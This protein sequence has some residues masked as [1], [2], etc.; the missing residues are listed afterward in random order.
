MNFNDSI[1]EWVKIDNVQ[2]EYLDKLKE[3]REKKNKLSDSLVNH[4]QENDMESNVFKIT[5]L[6][7]N[8]HMTKT[9]VQESLTFKLIEE[10]L[11]EYL[12][13]QYKTNDIIN[14]IKN[15][16]KKTE[17]YNMVQK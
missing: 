7:T 2:R 3:L 10:C 14:L 1:I 9:N 4:I 6:D 5:S 8:V 17:K 15:R 16:R 12:N 13:D 11:Y